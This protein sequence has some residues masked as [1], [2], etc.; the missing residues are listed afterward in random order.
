MPVVAHPEVDYAGIIVV[1]GDT[2]G[3][4]R[5]GPQSVILA[6]RRGGLQPAG[7]SESPQL[8]QPLGQPA[9]GTDLAEPFLGPLALPVRGDH[10]A[11][12]RRA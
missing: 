10:D 8:T 1:V 2:F 6:E 11:G 12:R 9:A 7:R 4:L 5:Q 3:E